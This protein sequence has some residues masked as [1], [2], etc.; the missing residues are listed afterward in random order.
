MSYTFKDVTDSVLDHI[1]R[2]ELEMLATCQ[3][4]VNA[5]L[6]W[7]QRKHKFQFSERLV[8]ITYPANALFIDIPTACEG[9]PRDYINAQVLSE[10]T[11]LSGKALQ[12]RR[13]SEIIT[14]K[15][16]LQR[17]RVD[18]PWETES[19]H[20]TDPSISTYDRDMRV[21]AESCL[22]LSGQRLGYF[23]RPQSDR[24]ILLNL[25]IWLPNLVGDTDTNFLLENCFDF[26]VLKAL[27]R[28]YIVIK[29]E[30]RTM[31]TDAELQ[32]GW[33]SCLQWDSEVLST[34]P[35]QI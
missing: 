3:R 13:Y 28:V 20:L 7:M 32:E 30:A 18:S 24:H 27:R 26:V 22:F 17:G 6:L 8:T 33:D 1:C 5:V 31:I 14:R 9:R 4:E 21:Y 29:E 16:K 19:P 12:I 10:P 35:Q 2:P 11:A 25:H 15:D 34:P 23:A